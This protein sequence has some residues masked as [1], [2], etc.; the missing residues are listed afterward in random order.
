MTFVTRLLEIQQDGV[1]TLYET[2][3]VLPIE[4]ELEHK[5]HR[6]PNPCDI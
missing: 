2:G 6:S 3:S 1:A 4:R 5:V